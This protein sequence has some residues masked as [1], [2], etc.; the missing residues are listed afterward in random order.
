[1]LNCI[2]TFFLPSKKENLNALVAE[3]FL[4]ALCF[5]GECDFSI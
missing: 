2:W 3:I 4:R 5:L 1:M